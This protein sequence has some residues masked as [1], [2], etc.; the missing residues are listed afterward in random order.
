MEELQDAIEDVQYLQAVNS[1]DSGPRPTD[2]W[3]FSTD[4]ELEEFSAERLKVNPDSFQLENVCSGILG[5][6]L[7]G[8]F[9]AENKEKDKHDFM[10]DIIRYRRL[11]RQ[12]QRQEQAQAILRKYLADGNFS[13]QEETPCLDNSDLRRRV[14]KRTQSID[15]EQAQ[16]R[17]TQ[18]PQVGNRLGVAGKEV[19]QLLRLLRGSNVSEVDRPEVTINKGGSDE[20]RHRTDRTSLGSVREKQPRSGPSGHARE[21]NGEYRPEL[22]DVLEGWVFAHLQDTLHSPFLLSDQFNEYV[23]FLCLQ[24]KPV[25]ESDFI[26]FRVLG[27]GGFGAVNGC[28]RG[29]SGKLFAMKVMNKRRI[30]IRQSDDLCWNERRILQAIRSPFVVSLKYAFES[31][32]DLFLILDLMTGGDLGFHLQHQGVFKPPMAQ[33]YT[34]RTVLGIGHLH[35]QGIVYRD[36]KPENIMLDERGRSRISDMGLACMVTPNLTGACGTRG[37]WSPEMRL[38]DSAGKRIPY[39]QC[40]DWFSL[41]CVVYEFLHGVSPFRTQRA[42][43]WCADTIKDK[44]KR[45]D[46]ATLEMDPEYPREHFDEVAAD[47]CAGLLVKDPKK[48]LG[49]K[50]ADEILAHA[51][52]KDLDLDALTLDQLDSPF[53]PNKDINAAPQRAIGSFADAGSKVHLSREDHALY[54][55]W[56]YTSEEDFQQEV[57]DFLIY[58]AN[59]GLELEARNGSC[60]VVS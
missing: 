17:V 23:K 35:Q 53:L 16:I 4:K 31:K 3:S 9:C 28:K 22:F 33:Y 6:Y 37:Y 58:R 8:Q 51:W 36:L 39:D 52:F 40:A 45:L 56:D 14:S 7:F 5:M 21:V 43:Q 42:V 44:E 32:H 30:K 29:A 13:I 38:R 24:E 1:K 18:G 47:F 46:K 15:L 54:E 55:G 34:A 11:R 19:E 27:R 59:H 49:Q 60:C 25:S 57:V 41:G 20:G 48:R 12:N 2:P 10:L 26:L 50:G